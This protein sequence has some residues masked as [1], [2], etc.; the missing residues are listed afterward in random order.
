MLTRGAF[1]NQVHYFYCEHLCLLEKKFHSPDLKMTAALALT[2]L[3][4]Q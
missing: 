2:T 3:K 1:Q 4:S